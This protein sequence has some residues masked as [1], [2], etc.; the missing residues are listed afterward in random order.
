MGVSRVRPIETG[1][2]IRRVSVMMASRRGAAERA[3]QL[4]SGF[5]ER[6]GETSACS[7]DWSWGCVAR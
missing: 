6:V 2:C 5:G 1:G 4:G 3:G 7:W